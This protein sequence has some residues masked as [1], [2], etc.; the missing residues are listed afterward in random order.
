MK[1]KTE[2]NNEDSSRN[3]EPKKES[4]NLKVETLSLYQKLH[5]I[6]GEM[7]SIEKKGFNQHDKYKFLREADV[8]QKAQSLFC[9]YGI[10]LNASLKS[11]KSE[12]IVNS[13]G[14]A[15]LLCNV[16][17]EY[18]LI[19]VH[20]P[21]E[22]ITSSAAGQGIDRGDKALYKALAGARKYFFSGTF[23]IGADDDA[24]KDSPD[25]DAAG[26]GYAGRPE[27]QQATRAPANRGAGQSNGQQPQ[28]GFNW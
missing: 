26:E 5:L 23:C 8:A 24:E 15:N 16:V 14:N 3:S 7:G 12:M 2:E 9:K 11:E 13:K 18:T 10:L 22:Q 6:M 17:M 27:R 21:Q 1:T 25:L 4:E 19:N 20:N 28:K